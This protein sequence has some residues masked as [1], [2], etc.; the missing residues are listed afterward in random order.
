MTHYCTPHG[1]QIIHV[2]HFNVGVD[3]Q[4]LGKQL[5]GLFLGESDIHKAYAGV[6]Q[7]QRTVFALPVLLVRGRCKLGDVQGI[8]LVLVIGKGILFLVNLIVPQVVL[9]GKESAVQKTEPGSVDKIHIITIQGHIKDKQSQAGNQCN[10]A[11]PFHQSGMGRIGIY[12][13][14]A[15]K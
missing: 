8:L 15:I 10:N 5:I 13:F 2:L 6:V 12:C 14:H 3:L 7:E 4:Q 9:A 11:G 1:L